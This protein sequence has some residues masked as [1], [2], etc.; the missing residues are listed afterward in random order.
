[1]YSPINLRSAIAGFMFFR[2]E[3]QTYSLQRRRS[4]GVRHGGMIA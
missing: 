2:R 1:M 4:L 3:G